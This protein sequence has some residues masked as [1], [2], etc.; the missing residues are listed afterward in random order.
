MYFSPTGVCPIHLWPV[1]RS[2]TNS[3]L[4]SSP[5]VYSYRRCILVPDLA[6]GLQMGSITPDAGP[7][8]AASL[9]WCSPSQPAPAPPTPASSSRS[10]PF[11]PAVAPSCA[12][13]LP[14]RCA[15]PAPP[16]SPARPGAAS[17]SHDAPRRGPRSRDAA[18]SLRLSSRRASRGGFPPTPFPRQPHQGPAA[19][20]ARPGRGKPRAFSQRALREGSPHFIPSPG[21]PGWKLQLPAC[22]ARRRRECR[23]GPA[24]W[25]GPAPGR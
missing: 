2:V 25:L 24:P 11:R 22:T 15:L 5:P 1:L 12:S 3:R 7:R 18:R 13:P 14:Q 10:G 17:P 9:R 4:R 21:R 19:T 16:R 6:P 23:P 8:P 20:A